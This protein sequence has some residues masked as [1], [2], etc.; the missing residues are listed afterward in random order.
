MRLNIGQ[1]DEERYKTF[2]VKNLRISEFFCTF[3]PVRKNYGTRCHE[4]HE[5]REEEGIKEQ[6]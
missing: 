4:K 3:A 2:W 1:S 6:V 5:S